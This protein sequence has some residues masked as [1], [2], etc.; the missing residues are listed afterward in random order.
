MTLAELREAIDYAESEHIARGLA[1]D[2]ARDMLDAALNAQRDSR[3]AL[4]EL[5]RQLI[6]A[7][8]RS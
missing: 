2:V 7:E 1:V 3:R 4:H 5:R 6:E 8:K